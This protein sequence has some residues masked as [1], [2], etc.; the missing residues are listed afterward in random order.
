MKLLTSNLGKGGVLV[1]LILASQIFAYAQSSRIQGQVFGEGRRPMADL[2]VELL[3]EVDSVLKRIKTDGIGGYY[4]GNLSAGRYTVRVR[5]FGTGY[6]EQSQQVEINGFVGGRQVSDSQQK[7][8]VLRT[9]RSLARKPASPGVIFA[10]DVPPDAEKAYQRGVGHLDSDRAALGVSELRNAIDI[11]PTYFLALDRLGVEMIKQQKWADA[12]LYFQRATAVHDKSANSWY[13]L[14]FSSYATG[15]V[16]EALEAATRA[17]SLS[18]DSPDIQLLLGISFRSDNRYLDA[19]KA[20]L[21]AK[22]LAEGKS[23]DV[24]W[25][26]ALLYA[27]NLKNYRLA[28]NELEAYLKVMPDHPNAPLL[29]KLITQWRSVA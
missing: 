22:K 14:A 16:K 24:L 9:Q 20:L 21:K 12:V 17:G 7:D 26:L 2:W 15:A 28:A 5:T 23:A 18:P 27:H 25:Q 1:A 4:F 10:Q 13:G 19:E 6:E 29:R 3:N 8:F 11:F